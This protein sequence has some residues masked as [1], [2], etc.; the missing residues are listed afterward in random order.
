M[1]TCKSNSM[2]E[3]NL[4]CFKIKSTVTTFTEFTLTHISEKSIYLTILSYIIIIII[5]NPKHC[6]VN[7][8][9]DVCIRYNQLVYL[10]YRI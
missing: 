5:T 6:Q 8:L 1:V 9:S 3:G 2:P 10:S 7:S 4:N